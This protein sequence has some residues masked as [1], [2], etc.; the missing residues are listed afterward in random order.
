MEETVHSLY[1]DSE[2]LGSYNN[3]DVHLPMPII[4]EDDERCYIRLKDYQQLN[5]F[6]NISN[7]LQNN[8]FSILHTIR[9]YSRTP[10]VGSVQ[11]FIDTNLFQTSGGNIYKPILNS[12]NDSVAHTEALIPNSGN[13]TIKL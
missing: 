1:I 8:T 6:Y 11:Y 12:V 13:F 10:I 9:T 5:S 2:S 4:V 3:F 7:D